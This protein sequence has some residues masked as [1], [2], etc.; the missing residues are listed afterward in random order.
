LLDGKFQTALASG[1][2]QALLESIEEM[3]RE[4]NLFRDGRNKG[5]PYS[6]PYGSESQVR[7]TLYALRD[8]L[9]SLGS[10]DLRQEN[11]RAIRLI[12]E[13]ER[14]YPASRSPEVISALQALA[15]NLEIKPAEPE[16]PQQVGAQPQAV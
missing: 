12:V 7:S 8:V 15:D 4:L 16:Q 1:M 3:V 10:D 2:A 13:Q 14:A 5:E 9:Q 11:A 6:S